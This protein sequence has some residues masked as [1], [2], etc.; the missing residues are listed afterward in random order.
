[1]KCTDIALEALHCALFLSIIESGIPNDVKFRSED[2]EN[3]FA[4]H[5][6]SKW[7]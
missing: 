1:M 3:L 6:S 5:C 4:I 2:Q 7:Q